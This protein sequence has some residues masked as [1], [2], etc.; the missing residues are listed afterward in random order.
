[1]A[2]L[3]SIAVTNR[4]PKGATITFNAAAIDCTGYQ[5]KQLQSVVNKLVAECA[6]EMSTDTGATV[7]GI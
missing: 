5:L 7:S 1:M 2:A 4:A 3:T 6:A